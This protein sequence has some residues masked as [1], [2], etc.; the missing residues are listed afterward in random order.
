MIKCTQRREQI[1]VREV[2]KIHNKDFWQKFYGNFL[3]ISEHGFTT[4]YNLQFK[5]LKRICIRN[6]SFDLLST[7]FSWFKSFCGP[8]FSH[9]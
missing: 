9:L 1:L 5:E 2:R 4:L 6:F 3:D 7:L 8:Q